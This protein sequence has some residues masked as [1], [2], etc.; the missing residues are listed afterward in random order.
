MPE[1]VIIRMLIRGYNMKPEHIETIVKTCDTEMIKKIIRF[2]ADPDLFRPDNVELDNYIITGSYNPTYED[3]IVACNN[4]IQKEVDQEIFEYW[5]YYV[6]DEILEAYEF[7]WRGNIDDPMS[8]WPTTDEELLKTLSAALDYIGTCTDYGSQPEFA[9][10]LKQVIQIAE[11]YKENKGKDVKDW[12]I[13]YLHRQIILL[14][15]FDRTELVSKSKKEVVKR[16]VDEECENEDLSAMYIKGYGCYGG[17]HI[18]DCDWEESRRLIT[19]LFEKTENP[20][21]A[22]TLGY[23]YYYGRCNKGVPEYDKAFQY[24]SIGATHGVMESMY[25]QADMYLSGKGCLL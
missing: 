3:L 15:Y 4:M 8:L 25:K 14:C 16:I 6:T 13:G 7:V 22:N 19:K 5:N 1:C 12:K 21:Y 20:T 18:Y 17:D 23:I 24:F 2:E 10:K 11:D 9:E